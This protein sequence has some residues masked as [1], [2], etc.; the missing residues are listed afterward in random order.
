MGMSRCASIDEL[1]WFDDKLISQAAYCKQMFWLGGIFLNIA[2]Q[3]HDEVIDRARVGIFFQ[4]PDPVQYFFAG[5]GTPAVANE[6][7]KQIGF[8]Q[9]KLEYLVATA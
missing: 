6:I 3:T 4:V 8:H 5:D 2:A 7:T 1:L 9:R